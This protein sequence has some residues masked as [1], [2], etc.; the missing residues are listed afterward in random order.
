VAVGEHDALAVVADLEELLGAAVQE[1]DLRLG[2]G[3]DVAVDGERDAPRPVGGGVVRTEVEH[4]VG[5]AR[6]E[7]PDAHHPLLRL[8]VCHVVAARCVGRQRER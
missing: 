2:G 5:V 6:V 7:H 3:D 8:I 1:A 4:H